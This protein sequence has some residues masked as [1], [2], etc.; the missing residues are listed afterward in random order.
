[1]KMNKRNKNLQIRNQPKVHLKKRKKIK[2]KKN[3]KKKRKKKNIKK[4]RKK[5]NIKKKR[6]KKK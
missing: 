2:R 3:I 6:K 1:M 4:K 5:K